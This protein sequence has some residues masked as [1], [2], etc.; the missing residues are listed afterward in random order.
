M[1]ASQPRILGSGRVPGPM[2]RND[3][4]TVPTQVRVARGA[5]AYDLAVAQGYDKSLEEWLQETNGAAAVQEH[6]ADT[7]PHPNAMSGKD[8]AT[9]FEALTE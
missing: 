7:T 8:Y 9:W 6:I 5:S 1:R 2:H 3:R 4:P